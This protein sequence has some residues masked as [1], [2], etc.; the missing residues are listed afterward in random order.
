M[1]LSSTT[2]FR[3]KDRELQFDHFKVTRRSYAPDDYMPPHAHDYCSISM[4]TSGTNEEVARGRSHLAFAGS[5]TFKPAGFEHADRVGPTGMTVV[6]LRWSDSRAWSDLGVTPTFEYDW[7]SGGGA[8]SLMR[9]INAALSESGTHDAAA[10]EGA[11]SAVHALAGALTREP[12]ECGTWVDDIR[13]AV[14][15]EFTLPLSISALAARVRR[16]PVSLARAFRSHYG[17]SIL[18]YA[19]RLRIERALQ[20][21]RHSDVS[22]STI[23]ASIGYAD[24]AHFCRF[25]RRLT[26][27]SPGAY[28][29]LTS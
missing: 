19:H 2:P 26:G 17:C 5:A 11:E 23:A 28:R 22:F 20:Q 12:G 25:F 29:R 7:I 13:A 1:L 18:A 24:Q 16:H 3:P 4:L 10:I 9:R 8:A 14:D 21:L 6:A 27:R 15:A